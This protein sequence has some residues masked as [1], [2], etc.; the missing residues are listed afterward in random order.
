MPGNFDIKMSKNHIEISCNGKVVEIPYMRSVT[1]H[2]AVC[3]TPKITIECLAG[4]ITVNGE[5]VE[6]NVVLNKPH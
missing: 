6:Y 5:T 2:N 1:I 4:D 3:E